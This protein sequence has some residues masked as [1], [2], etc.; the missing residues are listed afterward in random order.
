MISG[1]PSQVDRFFGIQGAKHPV[2][3][4]PPATINNFFQYLIIFIKIA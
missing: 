4:I 1:P 2:Y 3:L